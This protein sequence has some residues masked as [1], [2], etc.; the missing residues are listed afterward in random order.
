MHLF[1]LPGRLVH[2]VDDAGLYSYL[3]KPWQPEPKSLF[4]RPEPPQ[5][6]TTPAVQE[7][8]IAT[9]AA[10]I[11][12]LERNFRIIESYSF[13]GLFHRIGEAGVFDGLRFAGFDIGYARLSSH[14]DRGN[15]D[16]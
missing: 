15:S 1:L 3:I 8:N 6:I 7:A 2:L 14:A 9:E 11:Q 13:S 16:C 5:A 4:S 10:V 12:P